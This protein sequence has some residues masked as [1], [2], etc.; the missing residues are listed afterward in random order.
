[1]NRGKQEWEGRKAVWLGTVVICCYFSSFEGG[2]DRRGIAKGDEND[3][4]VI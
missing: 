3:A 1:M 4:C 2:S